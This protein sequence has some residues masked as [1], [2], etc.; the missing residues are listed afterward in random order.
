M[1]K[2]IDGYLPRDLDLKSVFSCIALS[3][4]AFA[5]CCTADNEP[6]ISGAVQ[7]IFP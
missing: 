3:A 6:S 7:K 5:G 1:E 4:L 2:D